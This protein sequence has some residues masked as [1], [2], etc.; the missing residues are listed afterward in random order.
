MSYFFR[1]TTALTLLSV[2]AHA[3]VG[4]GTPTPDAKAALE[5]K[6]T[7]KGLLIPRLTAAQR[8]ALTGVPQGL[9]VYQTDGTASGG[10]QTGFWY[11]GGSGG[12]VY[13]DTSAGSGLTLPFSGSY[14]G[15][16]G[17]TAFDVS[18]TNGGV[19]VRGAAPNTGVGVYGSSSTGSGVYG[20]ASGS[21]GYGVRG[22]ATAANSAGLYGTAV[23][24]NTYGVIGDAQTGVQGQG[25]S[26]P[27][28]S[29]ISSSGPA[30][31]AAKSGGQTG[32]AAELTLAGTGND[33]TA[34]FVSSVA[35]RPALR[36]LN[37][38]ASAQA[39]VR[40]VKTAGPDG[41]GVEGVV[42]SGG[43][44]AAGVLGNDKSGTSNGTGVVG[45]TTNGYGVRGVAS[46]NGGWGVSG[47][48]TNG[49]GVNSF[50]ASGVALYGA[51]TTGLAVQGIKGGSD[52][53]RVA[54]FTNTN[55]A[56]DST[57]AYIATSGDRPALRAVNTA[58]SAQ[59]AIRGV[60]Q[61]AGADGIG[62][63]GVITSGASGNAAGVLGN[64]QSGS[65]TGSGVVGLTQGGYGV[66][67]IASANG[68]YG[69]SGSAT[70]SYGVIGSSTSGSGVYGSSSTS[71]GVQGTSGS[72]A[73][74]YGSSNNTSSGTIIG[75]NNSTGGA[76][77]AGVLGLAQDGWGVRGVALTSGMG[78]SGQSPDSY[79]VSGVSSTGSGVY[80][81]T[82]AG[83]VGGVAGVIGSS[84]NSSGVGVLGTTVSGYGVR[85]EAT[86]SSGYGVSGTASGNNGYAVIGT[87]SGAAS[88]VY[89]G[90]SGTGRAGYFNQNGSSSTANALEVQNSSLGTSALFDQTN[91]SNVAPAMQ[92]R[93]AANT[94]AR[95]LLTGAG[96]AAGAG[97]GLID[98]NTNAT[99][100]AQIKGYIEPSLSTPSLDFGVRKGFGGTTLE[101]CLS[102]TTSIGSILYG[103][104][105]IYTSSNGGNDLYVQGNLSA[106]GT[107][108][109]KIDHPLD[110]ENKYL[111]HSC[112]ESPDMMNVY[113][114][115]AQ[116]DAQGTAVVQLPAY[117]EALNQDFR[118]QLTAVDAPGPNLYVAQKVRDNAFRIAGGAPGAEVSWQVTG[119]RHDKSA[120][121]HPL[122]PEVAKE[123]ANRGQYLSPTAYGL[124]ASRGIRFRAGSVVETP[125]PV[126]AHT[127]AAP[128]QLGEATSTSL[129]RR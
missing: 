127:T 91:V 86:G 106:S 122:V 22:A 119:I 79:G 14:G 48:A 117:F 89:G 8:T 71:Y 81:R 64:D 108:A 15:S 24:I 111:Y 13:L 34:V 39:A 69:V 59:A 17:T 25:G 115:I 16:S 102:L 73:A 126:S 18:H 129:T 72:S 80:G 4:I 28:L 41:S 12:W 95:L 90:A 121:A 77:A 96:A 44:N 30:V 52:L 105:Y 61:A 5:I 118:Y 54:Q 53:G 19:A 94:G 36:A 98:F 27:G 32:R 20:T 11:Y 43:G 83:N 47:S 74:V 112:V 37:T 78:V 40:G 67:G 7:D 42:T 123:A 1:L 63:E 128:G 84:A 109:F 2:A 38:N 82:G 3:Q 26:G 21:G 88:G 65:G 31:Q 92:V 87:A 56:N 75:I 97:A 9:L 125:G 45:L 103:N 100:L 76:T 35:P 101:R 107:K 46:A 85:G 66:R 93:A 55:A 104:V 70:N 33:S 124:P 50:S 58:T 10:A 6:A 113:N 99:P 120:L 60:K 62:V 68:G 51:S 114:G 57:A 110:P 49:R 116:L 23:G 29:G